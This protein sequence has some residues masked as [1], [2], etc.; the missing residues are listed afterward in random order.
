MIND[1]VAMDDST[2]TETI[3]NPAESKMQDALNN[4]VKWTEENNNR[5]NGAKTKEMIITFQMTM[6]ITMTILYSTI[7][8]QIEIIMYNSLE[9]QI[10]NSSGDYYEDKLICRYHNTHQ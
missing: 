6:T 8:I 9:N 5:I 7:D 10:I 4:V 1:L 3:D 2:V